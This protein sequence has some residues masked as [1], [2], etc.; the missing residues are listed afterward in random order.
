MG[1]VQNIRVT[2]WGGFDSVHHNIIFNAYRS[3]LL[4]IEPETIPVEATVKIKE[5]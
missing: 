1:M 2:G 4:T 3:K 5:Q